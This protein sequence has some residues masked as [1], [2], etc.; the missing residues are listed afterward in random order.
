MF[1]NLHYVFT[2]QEPPSVQSVRD[3]YDKKVHGL[4]ACLVIVIVFG[5]GMS[6]LAGRDCIK[7]LNVKRKRKMEELHAN[8]DAAR[9][10]GDTQA[11]S[12]DTESE[13]SDVVSPSADRIVADRPTN[14]YAHMLSTQTHQNPAFAADEPSERSRYE[15][16]GNGREY[17]DANR[18]RMPM[19]P[20][21]YSSVSESS[22]VIAGA[23][24]KTNGY[25]NKPS[26][27]YANKPSPGYA[28]KP[29]PLVL[30]PRTAG[31]THAETYSPSKPRNQNDSPYQNAYSDSPAK[32]YKDYPPLSAQRDYS[33]RNPQ[34]SL[35]PGSSY[36]PRSRD[37]ATSRGY[38]GAARNEYT[39]PPR[40]RIASDQRRGQDAQ[41][42][43]LDIVHG[44][45]QPGNDDDDS[46]PYVVQKDV[47]V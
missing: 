35:H 37:E 22:P 29:S 36:P 9:A 12:R 8:R 15:E 13:I 34:E 33:P 19:E 38:T 20:P 25:A 5:I 23:R 10:N 6:V 47:I 31:V 24:R 26:P 28:N 30:D 46:G 21:T 14:Q 45:G 44:H 40:E 39:D 43:R 2:I 4:T 16:I 7:A 32:S 1:A 41:P 42:K 3:S 27:G 17:E 11:L 18:S